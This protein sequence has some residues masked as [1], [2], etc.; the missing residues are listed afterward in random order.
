MS[1]I[2]LAAVLVLLA[3]GSATG[4]I[5]TAAWLTQWVGTVPFPFTVLVAGAWS[6]VLVR[7]AAM[8]SDRTVVRAFPPLVFL[9]TL[10]ALDLG[11]GGDTPVPLSLRGL[12]FLVFGALI[13]LWTAAYAPSLTTDAHRR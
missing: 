13:P 3:V 11:P 2:E 7:V 12:A 1:R 10:I 6:L 8:W 4:C 5:L 9:I